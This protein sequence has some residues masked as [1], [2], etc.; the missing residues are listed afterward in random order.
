MNP[1][2]KWTL[3]WILFPILIVVI[4]GFS[5]VQYFFDPAFYKKILQ[6]SLTQALGRKVSIGEARVSL[7]EGVG[8]TFEDFRIQ[9]RSQTFDLIH[10]KKLFL[11]AKVLPLLRKEVQWKRVILE[12]PTFRLLRDSKGQFNFVD[13]PL[14]GEE[15]KESHKRLIQTLSTL[16]GGSLTL[17]DG[18]LIF[19]D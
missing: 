19:T 11:K 12:E 18:R 1:R 2:K 14:T 8:V 4:L 13:E 16:F 7:W 10:S 5:F 9:D 3:L 15:L 17:K 6:D